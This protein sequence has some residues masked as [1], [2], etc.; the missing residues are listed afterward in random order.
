MRIYIIAFFSLSLLWITAALYM[1]HNKSALEKEYRKRSVLI[2]RYHSLEKMYSKKAQKEALKR[3]G[4]ML[5]L[6][7]VKPKVTKNGNKKIYD[8]NLDVKHADTVLNKLLNSGLVIEMFE[9]QRV[10]G[11]SLHVKVGVVL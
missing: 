7:G 5:R 11:H 10:D 2:G 3:F 4:T 9:V 6:Y 8:F 1:D